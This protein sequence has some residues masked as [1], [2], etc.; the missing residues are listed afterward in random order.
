MT[1]IELIAILEA[2][3]KDK[4]RASAHAVA[5]EALIQYIGDLGIAMA[6]KA[7]RKEYA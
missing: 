6:Y 5:D 2:C 3:A 7:I 1:R 4:D